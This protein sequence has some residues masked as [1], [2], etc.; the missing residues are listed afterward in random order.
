MNTVRVHFAPPK[1]GIVRPTPW[2]G[3]ERMRNVCETDPGRVISKQCWIQ[4]L[5]VHLH[6]FR[7]TTPTPLVPFRARILCSPAR[8]W[9]T[10]EWMSPRVFDR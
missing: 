1:N 7:N 5:S 3:T 8:C 2:T 9:V 6:P 4:I 10:F